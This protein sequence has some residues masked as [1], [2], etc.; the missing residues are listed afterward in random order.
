METARSINPLYYDEYLI[1]HL[2][3]LSIEKA[4]IKYE[5]NSIALSRDLTNL[6]KDNLLWKWNHLAWH[7]RVIKYKKPI[8]Y[9]I[10]ARELE[11][12]FQTHKI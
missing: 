2:N 11:D 4:K 12:T 6:V 3:I 10:C 7:S 5:I 9:G 8:I 1:S